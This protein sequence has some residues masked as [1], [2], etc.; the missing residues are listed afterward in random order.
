VRRAAELRSHGG[1][2]RLLAGTRDSFRVRTVTEALC[3]PRKPLLILFGDDL[4]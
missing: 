4:R 3:G 2:S 1:R